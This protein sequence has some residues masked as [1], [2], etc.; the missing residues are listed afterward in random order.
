LDF[1]ELA[2][3][4]PGVE[5]AAPRTGEFL[6]CLAARIRALWILKNSRKTGPGMGAP[7]KRICEF[8]CGLAAR[9]RALCAFWEL[10][11]TLP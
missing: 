11:V 5:R 6:P 8:L 4:G 3:N 7:P 9:I 10:P 1:E 2:Q